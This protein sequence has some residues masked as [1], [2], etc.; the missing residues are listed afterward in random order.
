[1]TDAAK[2]A[3]GMAIT[4]FLWVSLRSTLLLSIYPLI[5][6]FGKIQTYIITAVN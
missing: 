3:Q 6:R 1:M 2:T 4:G 5:F